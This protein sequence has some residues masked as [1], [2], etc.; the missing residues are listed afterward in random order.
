[1]TNH[2][3]DWADAEAQRVLASAGM[4]RRHLATAIADSL[5][6]A[7]RS[8]VEDSADVAEKLAAK[9]GELVAF[10]PGERRSPR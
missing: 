7:R 6:A 9:I 2:P 3:G 8:G 5:R 4:R 10:G 1:M